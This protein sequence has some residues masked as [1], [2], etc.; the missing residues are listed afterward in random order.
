MDNH[1]SLTAFGTK[2]LKNLPNLPL[3]LAEE[4]IKPIPL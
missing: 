3:N 2:W 1:L 4:V